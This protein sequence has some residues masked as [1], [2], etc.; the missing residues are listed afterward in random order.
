[1]SAEIGVTDE[2][3]KLAWLLTSEMGIGSNT[4]AQ[5]VA[6]HRQAAEDRVARKA[7]A[8]ECPACARGAR[9][10]FHAESKTYWHPGFGTCYVPEKIREALDPTG[11]LSG[12]EGGDGGDDGR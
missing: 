4:N 11:R 12:P 7:F 5:I 8:A 9:P 2:D 6:A 10:E 3:R 1:M